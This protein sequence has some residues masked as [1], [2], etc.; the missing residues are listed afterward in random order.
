MPSPHVLNSDVLAGLVAAS[1]NGVTITKTS[2]GEITILPAVTYRRIVYA[3]FSYITEAFADN[4][5][6]KTLFSIGDDGDNVSFVSNGA[7]D[8]AGNG[9]TPIPLFLDDFSSYGLLPANTALKAFVTPAVG[10][11]AGGL[12]LIALAVAA[13]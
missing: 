12:N 2:D 8:L 4:T 7:G 11:G 9:T 13:P 10:D 5:G 1:A 3:M 6:T